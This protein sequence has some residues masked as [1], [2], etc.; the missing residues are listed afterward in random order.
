VW[1]Q[2][3]NYHQRVLKP[4]VPLKA[5]GKGRTNTWKVD[6]L[7]HSISPI[8]IPEMLLVARATDMVIPH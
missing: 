1:I 3:D 2:N 8:D 7:K 5:V 4:L 6:D